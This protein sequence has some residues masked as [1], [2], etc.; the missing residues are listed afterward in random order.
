KV[1]LAAH[2]PDIVRMDVL[3]SRNGLFQGW[4]FALVGRNVRLYDP[5]SERS[6]MTDISKVTGRQPIRMDIGVEMFAGIFRPQ[7]YTVTASSMTKLEGKP[8]VQLTLKPK[9][10]FNDP[11][12]FVRLSHILVWMD[13]AKKVPLRQVSYGYL[14][15]NVPGVKGGGLVRLVEAR[16]GA[17]QPAGGGVWYPTQVR[18]VREHARRHDDAPTNV[19]LQLTRVNGVLVPRQLSASGGEGSSVLRY[20]NIRVNTGLP[21][22]T[23]HPR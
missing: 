13:P 2:I 1:R 18:M 9:P 11:K 23:F 6:T 17:F 8:A 19:T 20:S 21:A 4:K 10:G 5:I 3:S 12:S 22:S 16:F 14:P 7:N 15:R